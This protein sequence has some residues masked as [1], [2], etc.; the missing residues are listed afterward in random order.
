MIFYLKSFFLV[1]LKICC[2][3]LIQTQSV[4]AEPLLNTIEVEPNKIHANK[5]SS[6][7]FA[8]K[9]GKPEPRIVV[10][11]LKDIHF[12]GNKLLSNLKIDG[13]IDPYLL[14][15]IDTHQ[16]Y[17]LIATI[18][19]AYLTEGGISKIVVPPQGI[20]S[21]ILKI[22]ID[23]TL[24]K[25]AK[26]SGNTLISSATIETLIQPYLN[27]PFNFSQLQILS[28]EI[29]S[30]YRQAGGIARVI[31][32]PQVI[33]NGLLEIQIEESIFGVAKSRGAVD[34]VKSQQ[35]IDII[36]AAQNSGQRLA[37]RDLDRG[38]LLADDFPGVN[39]RG[40]LVEGSKA[41]STDVLAIIS[42]EKR[43]VG[44]LQSDNTG[45]SAIG[46]HRSLATVAIN[47]PLGLGD[48]LSATYLYSEGS[49]Y[50]RLRYT[51]PI[52]S[53]GLRVGLHGSGVDYHLISPEF[54]ALGASG[55]NYTAGLEASYP[56]IRSRSANLMVGANAQLNTFSNSNDQQGLISDY[57]V[58]N[59]SISLY[60]NWFDKVFGA[61]SN[62][63]NVIITNGKANLDNSPNQLLVAGANNA[64][65]SFTKIRY[66][67]SR[68]QRL[69]NGWSLSGTLSG[70]AARSNLDSS[71]MFYLGGAYGVQV[72]GN[73]GA[74]SKGHL[75]RLELSK[76]LSENST[77]VIFYDYG[78]VLLNVDNNFPGASPNNSSSMEGAGFAFF[79]N[80]MPQVTIKLISAFR[81]DTD[82]NSRATSDFR[83]TTRDTS[84]DMSRGS[85]QIWFVVSVGF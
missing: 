15:P 84:L 31:I 29:E 38:I 79:L 81:L 10:S 65:G 73:P 78:R 47:S 67:A 23:E 57:S 28:I 20:N 44:R 39:V 21:G 80:P 76:T 36:S 37:M 3:L 27:K 9:V 58:S 46:S 26:L 63:G 56:L 1:G 41:L 85:G 70:Q 6:P 45:A 52:R 54:S 43:V 40:I 11:V 61:G 13:L 30:A 74:G 19:A 49:E 17:A 60:W 14:K 18:E 7:S 35:V 42:D 59:Y 33:D 4:F 48:L 25:R 69:P 64:Q 12:T 5:N 32:P 66:S 72:Y 68:R 82:S 16:L 71:E 34:V 22:R 50:G 51:L 62:N 2:A 53:N 77:A 83:D 24:F 8:S 55:S 75:A